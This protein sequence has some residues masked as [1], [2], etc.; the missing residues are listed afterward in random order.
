LVARRRGLADPGGP[1]TREPIAAPLRVRIEHDPPVL[2]EEDPIH[3]IEEALGAVLGDEHGSAG[4]ERVPDERSGAVGVELR[5]RLVE[6]QQPRPQRERGC[7]AH[8][9]ELAARELVRRP[10][11]EAGRPDRVQRAAR[12]GAD[13]LGPDAEVLQP[14]GHLVL[15]PRHHDLVLRILEERRNDTCELGW[16]G[17]SRVQAGHLDAAREAAAVKVGHE[18]GERTKQG[19]L[20]GARSAQDEDGLARLQRE[21]DVAQSRL[22]VRVRERETLDGR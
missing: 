5:R 19:G 6:E 3:R 16:R 9:L 20:S 22:R 18:P 2:E 11:R 17:E 13:R 10:R 12:A 21:R 8:P 15:D 7:E 14:E 4:P 1:L